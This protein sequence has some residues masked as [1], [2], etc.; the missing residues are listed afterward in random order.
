M[1]TSSSTLRAD[2]IY[3]FVNTAIRWRTAFVWV[4]YAYR[5]CRFTTVGRLLNPFTGP[6]PTH[7]R[8]YA[9]IRRH[10]RGVRCPFLRCSGNLA[11][12]SFV[13]CPHRSARRSDAPRGFFF[14]ISLTSRQRRQS[15]R[16]FS[17]V[18]SCPFRVHRIGSLPSA[19]AFFFSISTPFSPLTTNENDRLVIFIRENLIQHRQRTTCSRDIRP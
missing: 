14:F 5:M 2:G 12:D 3:Q 4:G 7:H 16:A 6:F 15:E 9:F 1:Q 17:R 13:E 8:V 10:K 18:D 11:D 19:I